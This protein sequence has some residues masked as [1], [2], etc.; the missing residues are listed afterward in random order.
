MNDCM[1]FWRSAVQISQTTAKDC[2]EYNNPRFG[3][4][5]HPCMLKYDTW[6]PAGA[7]VAFVGGNFCHFPCDWISST[8]NYQSASDNPWG[9]VQEI[10]HHHQRNWAKT[11]ESGEMSNNAVNL[12]IYAKQNL[13]SGPRLT[14][15]WARYSYAS[16]ELNDQDSYGLQRYSTLL[17]FFGVDKFKE[18]LKAEQEIQWYPRSDFGDPGSEM[19][20]AS[21]V[22]N[23]NLRY[24]WNFNLSSDEVLNKNGNTFTHT[25][26][27]YHFSTRKICFLV[28][29]LL[30]EDEKQSLPICW[31]PFGRDRLLIF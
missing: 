3:R 23:R 26:H 22:F 25:Q 28:K 10:N 18:F 21:R 13:C 16:Y 7:A 20:R 11:Q 30:S 1:H 31:T 12:V 29:F 6:V 24:H 4:I 2:D 9:T 14:S 5:I 19:L 8:V 27:I 15:G 17:H